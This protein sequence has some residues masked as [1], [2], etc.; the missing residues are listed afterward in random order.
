ME[1]LEA[2]E[3]LGLYAVWA[4]ATMSSITSEFCECPLVSSAH[5]SFF[6]ENAV[7]VLQQ[8]LSG[9]LAFIGDK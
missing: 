8:S 1:D 3:A 5:N 6:S 4:A 2:C 9:E 7:E